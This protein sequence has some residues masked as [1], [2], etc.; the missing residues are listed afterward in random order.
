MHRS[1]LGVQAVNTDLDGGESVHRT[2]EHTEALV[3]DFELGVLWDE[4]GLVGDIVPF[5]NDFPRADIHELIAPDILHQLI[6]GC[7]KDHLVDWVEQYLYQTHGKAQAEI[8]LAD[9][10]HR[11][12]VAPPFS[13]LRRFH[14]GRGFK[15]WTG[16]DTKG[17]MKVY[18]P[19]IVG[20]VP[21]EMVRSIQ[22]YLDFCYLV[23][24]NVH[25]PETLTQLDEALQH[26]HA[27]RT[28]F[29][30]TGVRPTGFSLPRQHS[31]KHYIHLI[32]E[33]A[34][35]N[36]LCS[37]ITESKHIEAIKDPYRCSNRFK[38]L[39]QILLTNQRID[40]LAASRVDFTEQGMLN[41][42]CL[43]AEYLAL[44]P[45]EELEDT[46]RPAPTKRRKDCGRAEEEDG[47]VSGPPVL[48][49]VV[50]AATPQ[51]KH[52]RT[53]GALGNEIGQPRLL[54]LIRR[55]LYDQMNPDSVLTGLDVAL[56]ACPQFHEQISVFYSAASTYYAPSDPS[57]TGGMHREHLRATPMWWKTA[58]RFDC[59]F[60]N[61]GSHLDGI[62]SL[63]I[64]RI[65]LFFSFK[66]RNIVYPCALVHWFKCIADEPD[67]DTG[68]YIV[69]P[70]SHRGSPVLSV[71]H[72]D[73]IVRAA[74]LIVVYGN[75]T[76]PEDLS[77]HHA[78]DA[79]QYFYVNKYADHH[80]F[81]TIHEPS[82]FR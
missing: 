58:P 68:L 74:H 21:Q 75:H 16:D 48:A 61:H 41:G 28:I 65:R 15:Q 10:D 60:V 63:D 22:A 62:H 37:S 20:Y 47:M 11:I 72:L 18:L 17:L 24:R 36:G 57:G 70:E 81:E 23:R 4:Y 56:E 76:V 73:T 12:A 46:E 31:L 33:F 64:V 66:R 5:T 9:I 38:P 32:W 35:P 34:A 52:A 77:E 71:I 50:M 78:L 26:F 67:E 40:K 25:T 42:S 27:N 6:K 39:G 1:G 19:A 51:T 2:R 45:D 7:F 29:Q 14:E 49:Y 30:M 82:N 55:F 8:I 44:N 79:F 54:E 59:A 80:A 43:F 13:G 69:R 3:A 53:A